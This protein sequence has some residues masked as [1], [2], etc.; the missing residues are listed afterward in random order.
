MAQPVV[1]LVATFLLAV[2][3][4]GATAHIAARYVLG[5][6]PIGRAFLVGIVPALVSFALRPY[7][8]AIVIPLA[9]GADFFAI[10][11]V[12]R[13]QYRT[14]GLVAAAHYTVSAIAGITVFNLV[15][16]LG[17]APV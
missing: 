7:A 14:A 15:R 12:Y 9:A 10:R 5:D 1:A 4:Y 13:L 6:A 2:L 3:F 11:A 17:T 8:P 16:L